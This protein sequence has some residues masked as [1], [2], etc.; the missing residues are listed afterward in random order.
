MDPHSTLRTGC[1][2]WTSEQW[3]GRFYPRGIADGER[4]AYYAGRFDCVEVDATYYA[5]P[6]PFMVRAWGRK[7]PP[8]FLF[9]LKMPR[10]FLDPKKPAR[11][12]EVLSFVR[13]AESLGPK[14][15]AILLQ[16]A[17]W[18]TA[19]R[20]EGGGNLDFLRQLLDLLPEGPR[21]A[22]ELRDAGWYRA[23]FL[24][25][26]AEELERRGVSLCWSA[27]NYLEIPPVRTTSWLYVRF[28]GDHTSIPAETHGEIRVDRTEVL[29]TWAQRIREAEPTMTFAFFNNHFEG[30]APLS[31]NRFRKE[32]GLDP[33]AVELPRVPRIDDYAPPAGPE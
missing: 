28:I 6:N 18:F 21:Y 2:S 26:L 16:F 27:L 29:R 10:A 11:P 31:V 24:E 14:L 8:G 33:V 4:L 12:E 7:T 32:L 9:A 1:S 13:V 17:P 20:T 3:A 22:V 5:P 23:G 25:P 15:G 30:Y 19:P